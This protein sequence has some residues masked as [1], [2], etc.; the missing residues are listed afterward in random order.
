MEA[1]LIAC[2]LPLCFQPCQICLQYGG[3]GVF[4]AYIGKVCC[5]RV[6]MWEPCKRSCPVKCCAIRW[7]AA[8]ED[9]G[10]H[11]QGLQGEA[12][13]AG[14]GDHAG[15]AAKPGA[16]GTQPGLAAAAAAARPA[17]AL[18]AANGHATAGAAAICSSPCLTVMLHSA[19]SVCPQGLGP[20]LPC[21]CLLISCLTSLRRL[22]MAPMGRP[23]SRRPSH[24][25][26]ALLATK[27]AGSRL[28]A[29]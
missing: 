25:V 8:D 3:G 24:T 2:S 11:H 19:P 5:T 29:G 21:P 12:G 6:I 15:A 13:A 18:P 27:V 7:C 1:C 4:D 17:A 10:A 23:C 20:T 26:L 16:T 14:Q 22:R 28:I 9:G